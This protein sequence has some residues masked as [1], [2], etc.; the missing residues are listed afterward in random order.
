[1]WK[2]VTKWRTSG[3][4]H[5]GYEE[6]CNKMADIRKTEIKWRTSGKL[7]QNGGHLTGKLKQNGGNQKNRNKMTCA[8]S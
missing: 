7:K 8:L 6:N 5:R 1:M 3:K 2:T 4:L